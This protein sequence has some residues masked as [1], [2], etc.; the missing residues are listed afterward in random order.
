MLRSRLILGG[1]GSGGRFG[2]PRLYLPGYSHGRR[3]P[4]DGRLARLSDP[5]RP[6]ARG[7]FS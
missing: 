6:Q 7:D 2:R 1:D 3:R 5:C 4:G